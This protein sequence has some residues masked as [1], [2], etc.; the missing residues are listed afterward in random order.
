MH[1]DKVDKV[2]IYFNLSASYTFCETDGDWR[3]W[4]ITLYSIASKTMKFPQAEFGPEK[5]LQ[6]KTKII[7]SKTLAKHTI[8]MEWSLNKYLH[9]FSSLKLFFLSSIKLTGFKRLCHCIVFEAFKINFNAINAINQTKIVQSKCCPSNDY[10]L[11]KR[12][13]VRY[14]RSND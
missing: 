9:I 11:I 10:L 7:C 8:T 4:K 3:R 14:R 12:M 1:L 5:L 6:N 13:I 2:R